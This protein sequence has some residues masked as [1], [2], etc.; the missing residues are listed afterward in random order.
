MLTCCQPPVVTSSMAGDYVLYDILAIEYRPGDGA[1]TMIDAA[2]VTASRR[3]RPTRR[4][5]GASSG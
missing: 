3:L 4:F 2:F 5:S 1:A